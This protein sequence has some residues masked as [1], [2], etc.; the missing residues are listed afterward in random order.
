M[1]LSVQCELVSRWQIRGFGSSGSAREYLP[2]G[3]LC[4]ASYFVSLTVDEMAFLVEVIV[5]VGVD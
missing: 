5:D 4:R 3:K 2:L 1:V